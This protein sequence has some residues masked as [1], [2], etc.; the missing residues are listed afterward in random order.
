MLKSVSD[1]FQ[2]WWNPPPLFPNADGDEE[3]YHTHFIETDQVLGEG[4]FGIVKVV[5]Q[6]QPPT[7][8][9]TTTTNTS[10]EEED[11]D[12]SNTTQQ[13]KPTKNQYAVKI[14]PKGMT[15]RDN[16][17]YNPINP[18]ALQTEVAILQKL[19]GKRHSSPLLYHVYETPKSIYLI[20]Q[21]CHGGNLMNYRSTIL[22]QE[23]K[24]GGKVPKEV[25]KSVAYQLLDAVDHCAKNGVIHR[26]IKPDNIMFLQKPVENMG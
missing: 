23:K 13:E 24:N 4:E 7:L 14:L 15:I 19:S 5:L 16:V 9:T 18:T 21:L 22:L 17:L 8:P 3:T 12:N 11:K 26:D 20:T 2:A 1:R 25:V 6:K 10:F